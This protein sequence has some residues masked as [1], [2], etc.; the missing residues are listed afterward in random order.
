MNK[1]EIINYLIGIIEHGS[2][3]DL[4]QLYNSLTGRGLTIDQV[5][6]QE[7]ATAKT[8]K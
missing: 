1:Q 6:W 7:K 2:D 4:L 5:H 3:Q 8:E